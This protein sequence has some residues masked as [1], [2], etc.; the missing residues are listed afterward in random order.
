MLLPAT[1]EIEAADRLAKS[2]LEPRVVA[3]SGEVVVDS[4]LPAERRERLDASPEALE[5]LVAVLA[6]PPGVDPERVDPEVLAH[7]DEAAA[8]LHVVE[9][10]DPPLRVVVH[11]LTS[12]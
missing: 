9:P 4:R 10:R 12:E 6:D 7:R 5:R 1:A 3:D 8:P 2:L 11:P